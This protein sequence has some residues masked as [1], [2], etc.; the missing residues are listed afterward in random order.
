MGDSDVSAVY[1][2][3]YVVSWYVESECGTYVQ[4]AH[5][6]AVFPSSNTT[7]LESNPVYVIS[8]A[9]S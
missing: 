7:S 4:D 2:V 8:H 5:V 3:S 1:V 9:E 6:I